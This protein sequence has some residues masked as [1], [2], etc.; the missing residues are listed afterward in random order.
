MEVPKITKFFSLPLFFENP[1][2][3]AINVVKHLLHQ[4]E[5]FQKQHVLN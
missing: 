1:F 3:L 2:E 4:C 5:V